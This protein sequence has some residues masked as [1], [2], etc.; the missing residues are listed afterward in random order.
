VFHLPLDAARLLRARHRIMDYLY[1]HG[2]ARAA[3]ND[4]VVA[5][6]EAMSNA[7]RHSGAHEDIE[8]AL[9]FEGPDLVASVRD[10][11]AGFETERFDPSRVPDPLKPSGR[12]LFMIARL[13]DDVE[14]RRNGGLVVHAVKRDVLPAVAAPQCLSRIVP[15]AQTDRDPR[16]RALLD[17][18]GEAFAALDWEYRLFYLN[19]EAL[20][21]LG[22][23]RAEVLGRT[24][25][26]LFPYIAGR[27]IGEAC[28]QAMQVG[29]SAI[30]VW[31]SGLKPGCWL[32]SRVYPTSFGVSVFSRDITD[33][34]HKE[35]ER[36]RLVVALRESE[37]RCTGMKGMLTFLVWLTDAD[38]RVQFID[39]AGAEQRGLREQQDGGLEWTQVLHHEDRDCFIA[40]F[41]AA[42][43]ERRAFR[44]EARMMTAAGEWRWVEATAS[45]RFAAS[46]EYLGMAGST[47][48]I[49]RY[50]HSE[51]QP[52]RVTEER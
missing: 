36:L 2:V 50:K 10:H 28:K 12:G 16:Q 39:R 27:E 4:I 13:M 47:A 42:H 32:E 46:G 44:A 41:L 11:G 34:V 38:G 25:W 43:R 17:D 24:V 48:D 45:P 23:S 51:E 29:S 6:E 3:V 26:E 30:V 40:D 35:Q 19:E 22:R 33:R 18:I 1:E 5:I 21:H 9:R 49:S 14:L 20:R 15:G 31:E 8:V 7:V 37:A 52:R